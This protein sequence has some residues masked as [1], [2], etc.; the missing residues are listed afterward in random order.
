MTKGR[1]RVAAPSVNE[2]NSI[3]SDGFRS[4]LSRPS[5]IFRRSS[6]WS[7][8]L[9][10]SRVFSHSTS[11]TLCRM[12]SPVAV[13]GLDT[14]RFACGATASMTSL[15]P[16]PCGLTRSWSATSP[17]SFC[18]G[19]NL[20]RVLRYVGHWATGLRLLGGRDKNTGE[21]L[22][23]AGF[24]APS[25]PNLPADRRPRR[26]GYFAPK[27]RPRLAS[28][29]S[30]H[31]LGDS[32]LH[33]TCSLREEARRVAEKSGYRFMQGIIYRGEEVMMYRRQRRQKRA[34]AGV[35]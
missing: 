22:G 1:I 24:A 27:P 31:N 35:P 5:P 13:P 14:P 25:R 7:T 2:P 16:L 23:E 3:G 6:N 4:N 9:R 11:R 12:S 21:F 18:T 29:Q 19:G 15:S 33:C 20:A 30:R 28:G 26:D 8:K 32:H 34:R 17:H 10:P